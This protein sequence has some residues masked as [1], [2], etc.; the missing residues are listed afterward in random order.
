MSSAPASST[1]SIRASSVVFSA[2]MINCPCLV[3]LNW[4]APGAARFPPFL[5]NVERTSLAA[6]FLL[7]VVTSTIMP[8]PPGPYPSYRSCSYTTPGSSPVP[9]LIALS[10][11]SAGMLAAFAFW[12]TM[13]RRAFVDGSPPPSLAASVRSL[14]R[15]LNILPFLASIAALC[16]FVVA[17]LL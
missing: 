6:R 10:T 17:H 13:R 16:L 14:L 8:I 4:S 1:Q 2:L 5:V 3:K 15:A 9:F 11:L 12:I 7:S